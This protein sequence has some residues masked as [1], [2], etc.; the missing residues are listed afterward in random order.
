MIA[1]R[2]GRPGATPADDVPGAPNH[3]APGAA[4]AVRPHR[5]AQRVPTISQFYGI[6]IRMYF[7]HH[8]PPHIHA[9]YAGQMAVIEIEFAKILRG[10]VP[11]RALRLVRE[12]IELNRVALMDDWE[13]ARRHE[14]LAPIPPLP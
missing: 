4:R 5:Q 7:D 14:P 12:W 6:V 3:E 10:D 8:P 9:I 13:R 2:P 1:T 11:G